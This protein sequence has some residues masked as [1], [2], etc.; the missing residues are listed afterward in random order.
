MERLGDVVVGAGVEALDL[1]APA[2]ARGQD[3]DQHGAAVLAPLLEHAH[4][5]QLGQA[6]I[7]DHRVIGF[8]VAQIV[9]FLAV[10]RG[11]HHIARRLERGGD[12]R[13]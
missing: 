4:A 1:V 11:V 7:E 5:V 12:L 6:Q 9:A 10:A 13:D 2:V 8:G 3:Q